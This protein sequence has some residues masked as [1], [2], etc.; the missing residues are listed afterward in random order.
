[1][2][3]SSHINSNLM[4]SNNNNTN[5]LHHHPGGGDAGQN[6]NEN[7]LIGNILAEEDEYNSGSDIEESKLLSATTG[8][9]AGTYISNANNGSGSGSGSGTS[10]VGASGVAGGFGQISGKLTPFGG[11]AA[12]GLPG[13]SH[14]GGAFN[15]SGIPDRVGS[16]SGGDLN[17]K[18]FDSPTGKKQ[19]ATQPTQN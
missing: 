12:F 14:Y 17:N 2:S 16:T 3:Q 8:A 10:N 11:P 15:N 4:N 18:Y 19:L 7:H 13:S 6:E 5:N 1:M 9:G